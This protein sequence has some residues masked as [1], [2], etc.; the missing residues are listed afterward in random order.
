V[1]YRLLDERASVRLRLPDPF[2]LRRSSSRLRDL[3]YIMID[4]TEE[5]FRSAQI[6]ISY[7]LGG[8]GETRGGGR[9]RR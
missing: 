9:G 1:R 5:S 3:D 2:G 7:A 8:G 6:S 4:R